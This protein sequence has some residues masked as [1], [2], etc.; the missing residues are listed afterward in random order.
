MVQAVSPCLARYTTGSA[1]LMKGSRSLLRCSDAAER[2][3]V[4]QARA[5]ESA[6]RRSEDN[7]F[8]RQSPP[9]AMSGGAP[10]DPDSS[11]PAQ[12]VCD[13]G[14]TAGVLS[15]S[16]EGERRRAAVPGHEFPGVVAAVRDGS[17]IR[18][19]SGRE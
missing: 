9:L 14:V 4:A 12:G 8:V 13:P 6:D 2:Y 19:V 7:G 16:R 15:P 11:L 17:D 5:P 1:S 10:F 3:G 18:S